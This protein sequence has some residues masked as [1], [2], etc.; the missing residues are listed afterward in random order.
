MRILLILSFYFLSQL[1]GAWFQYQDAS[2]NLPYA[3]NQ[4]QMFLKA[5]SQ[6]VIVFF[7]FDDIGL[8]FIQTSISHR[9]AFYLLSYY[10]L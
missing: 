7:I 5:H 1:V 2:Q 6:R 3:Q 10:S 4:N 8:N 9:A